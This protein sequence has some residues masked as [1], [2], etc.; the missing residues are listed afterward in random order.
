MF[1]ILKVFLALLVFRIVAPPIVDWVV[2]PDAS[3]IFWL[4]FWFLIV[5]LLILS[6]MVSK[7]VGT[8]N[9]AN[10]ISGSDKL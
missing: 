5:P 10:K 9:A 7:T 6:A 8:I 1:S 3:F 4:F 2:G